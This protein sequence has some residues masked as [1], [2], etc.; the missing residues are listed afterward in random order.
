MNAKKAVRE[1]KAVF[2]RKREAKNWP[3]FNIGISEPMAVHRYQC[4]ATR[5]GRTVHGPCDCGGDEHQKELEAAWKNLLE[6]Q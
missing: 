5:H 6:S 2:F 1:F 3:G 4:P